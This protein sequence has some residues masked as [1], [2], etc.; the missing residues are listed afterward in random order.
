M[1]IVG[2]MTFGLSVD[3]LKI[4][5]DG[6]LETATLTRQILDRRVGAVPSALTTFVRTSFIFYLAFVRYK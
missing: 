3:R 4:S 2:Q 1:F 6:V 5:E